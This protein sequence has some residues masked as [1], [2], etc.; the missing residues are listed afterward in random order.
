MTFIDDIPTRKLVGP[1]G[2]PE[3]WFEVRLLSWHE[4]EECQ[5]AVAKRSIGRMREMGGEIIT[6]MGKIEQERPELIAKAREVK[7]SADDYDRETL[8]TKSV[9]GWSYERH[10]QQ[11]L[12]RKLTEE[13]FAW[14]FGEIAKLYVEDDAER[15]DASEDSTTI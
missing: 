6:A 7:K 14:L 10:F 9:T 1:P 4:L 8:V 13:T 11:N 5:T 3:E 12:I 15:K 2:E